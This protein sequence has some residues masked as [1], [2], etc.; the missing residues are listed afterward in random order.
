MTPALLGGGRIIM[1]ALVIE[2]DVTFNRD[3]GPASASAILFVAGVMLIFMALGRF[4]SLDRVF[5][6]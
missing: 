5:S 1:M 3:W 4:M 6:R 2:R